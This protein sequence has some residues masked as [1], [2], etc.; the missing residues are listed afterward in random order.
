MMPL[1]SGDV[2]FSLPLRG[3]N[4]ISMTPCVKKL[5][6]A[7][8]AGGAILPLRHVLLHKWRQV[9]PLQETQVLT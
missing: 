1:R 3:I 5:I 9:T 8:K 4:H 2:M 6:P 7:Q